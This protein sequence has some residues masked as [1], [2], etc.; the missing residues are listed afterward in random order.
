MSKNNRLKREVKQFSG[1]DIKP[2]NVVEYER[3]KYKL[4]ALNESQRHFIS[5]LSHDNIVVGAGAAGTGKTYIASRI[6]GELYRDSKTISQIIMTRPNVEVG[7]KMG[8]LPGEIEDKY[9]PYMLPFKKGLTDEL[10]N[11]FQSDLGKNI[12][13]KPLA[14]MRGETFDNAVMLLDEAQNTTVAEMKM[15]LSRVGID[16]RIFIT[17]DTA[18]TDIKGTNGLEWLVKQ[19]TLQGLSHEVIRFTTADCVRSDLCMSM[20]QMIDNE[21]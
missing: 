12:L 19:I 16:S 5:C 6:A 1:C 4:Y 13:P 7:Q 11:K 14:Y 17:G 9:E 8:Y 2:S 15:F 10:G 18:Q 20:L 21:V 3:N